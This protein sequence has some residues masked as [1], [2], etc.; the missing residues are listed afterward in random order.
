MDIFYAHSENDR[1]EKHSLADHLKHTSE[2]MESFACRN[3]YRQVFRLT[4]LLHDLGKY[5]PEFQKYLETG[6]KRGSVPHASWG[7]GYARIHGL[8]EPSIV[9]NGHHKGL[10]D[11]SHWKNDTEP[12]K[13]KD[14]SGFEQIVDVFLKDTAIDEAIFKKPKDFIFTDASFRDVFIRY[15]FSA[16]TDADWLST[17]EHFSRDKFDLRKGESLS[18]DLMIKKLE[19]EFSRKSQHGE[20]N[21]LRNNARKHALEKAHLPCG[22]YSLALPTGLG[23]TL[24]SMAWALRHAKTNNLKRIIIVLPY[25]NIIDQT[26]GVFKDIFGEEWVLEHHS[27]YNEDDSRQSAYEEYLSVTQERKKLACENWDYPIIVTTTVQFFESLFGNRTS[28]C[29]KIH[30]VAESLVIFDEVQ[31]LPKE[32]I[33]PTLQML[34]GIQNV[35]RVSFLFCT[36]TQPAFEKRQ[37]FD[38]ITTITPL[39][40]NTA[41]LYAKTR[42][43]VYHLLN[44]LKPVDNN[45]LIDNVILTG[46]SSLVIFNT[47]KAAL[48]FF[49]CTKELEN[50]NRKYHLST[51]MCPSHRK[52]VIKNIKEDLKAKKKILV[53]STQL[54]E[55]GVD[56]DFPVVFR[57]IA[58]LE[59]VIQAAGRCNREG[60]LGEMGGNVS[61]F[62]LLDRGMP[63]KTYAA[64]AGYAEELIVTDLN[65]LSQ[66]DIFNK[67][68]A[69]VIQ[70]YVDPDKYHI[71]EARSH[72]EYETVNDAYH[73]I[74]DAT[75]GLYIYNYNDE[76]MKL[77]H[78]LEYKEFLSREDYRRMQMF[79]VQVYEIFCIK[80]TQMCKLMPQGFSVWYG[81]YDKDTGIS[82]APLESDKLIL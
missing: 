69:S 81:N 42:R 62:K 34:E 47:K 1:G 17:E 65:S 76:S 52:E 18:I 77:F 55:A 59:A 12:F 19:E 27:N 37:G 23:K 11:A 50:W 24:T 72:F 30:N 78:S 54:I 48:E 2:Y 82:T 58:P 67:Y 53:A 33:L 25:I 7:A 40:E 10:S 56:F 46:K 13:R 32:V 70:L 74:R 66:H 38:G 21:I 41:E 44:E 29:R 28:K 22:F 80:N 20:I 79:T 4:G 49:N 6:G 36:A 73:L 71:N 51:A 45:D 35:M 26:A 61:L 60:G 16:L 9:I 14:V 75:R 68:Y 3:E 5:Q 8:L 43:V 31:T 15:L 39:I 63:D 57:E 64:C